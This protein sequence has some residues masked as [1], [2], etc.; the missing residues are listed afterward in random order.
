MVL[1]FT[2]TQQNYT[3]VSA[4]TGI[5]SLLADENPLFALIPKPTNQPTIA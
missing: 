4:F 5:L 2:Q 3:P 1:Q